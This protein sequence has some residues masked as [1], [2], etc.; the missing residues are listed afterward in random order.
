VSDE[1][2]RTSAGR[3]F[4]N[5]RSG[6]ID[7]A[8]VAKVALQLCLLASMF[9]SQLAELIARN[10]SVYVCLCVNQGGTNYNPLYVETCS[11]ANLLT[12]SDHKPKTRSV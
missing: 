5:V 9:N 11:P 7:V 2:D 8:A 1:A 3:L 10:L 6:K 12:N 4:Q